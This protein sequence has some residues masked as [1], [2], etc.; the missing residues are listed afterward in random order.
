MTPKTPR[1]VTMGRPG[2]SQ[3]FYWRPS[4]TLRK[5]GWADR[6]LSNDLAFAT[7][8]A[9]ALNADVERWRVAKACGQDGRPILPD[10]VAALIA[11]YKAHDDFLLLGDRTRWRYLQCLDRIGREMGELRLKAVTP[12]LVQRFKGMFR[13][14][15]AQ[16]NYHLSVLRLLFSFGIRDGQRGQPNSIALG[17][18]KPTRLID[19][20]ALRQAEARA[21]PA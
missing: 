18:R 10:T 4:A 9:E 13:L 21:R 3:L 1:L 19:R 6:R 5:A 17:G 14:T 15:P 12:P 16:G 20:S 2:G 7:R 11:A 8:E